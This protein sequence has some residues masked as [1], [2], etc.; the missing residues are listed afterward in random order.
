[1]YIDLYVTTF[2]FFIFLNT[3]NESQNMYPIHHTS[4]WSSPHHMWFTTS[5]IRSSHKG[6]NPTTLYTIHQKWDRI[7]HK[8]GSDLS[9]LWAGILM[10][11][12]S[13]WLQRR[14][15]KWGIH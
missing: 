4:F 10:V 2:I 11:A 9:L 1:L 14:G 12:A 7:S 8:W 5:R 3:T 13:L 6:S 15:G